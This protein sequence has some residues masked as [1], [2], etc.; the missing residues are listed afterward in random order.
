MGFLH[1]L[2]GVKDPLSRLRRAVN[3]QRWADVLREE[4]VLQREHLSDEMLV[5]LDETVESAANRL[6]EINLHEGEACLRSGDQEGAVEHFQLAA[7]HARSEVLKSL[8][9]QHLAG[10]SASLDAVLVSK[11]SKSCC[12][13]GCHSTADTSTDSIDEMDMELRLELSLSSYPP[14][15]A[16]RYIAADSLFKQALLL[17][18]DGD[19]TEAL[20][21]FDAVDKAEQD[22]LYYFERGSLLVRSGETAQGRRCLQRSVEL[23]PR[24]HLA[25]ETL[26]SL[27][28]MEEQPA[29]AEARLNEMLS[30]EISTTFCFSRLAQIYA[31]KNDV[32]AAIAYGEQALASGPVEIDIIVLQSS[33]LEKAGQIAEAEA[34][35]LTLPSG[36]CGGGAHYL[37][38]EFWLRHGKSLN[39][40]LEAFKSESRQDPTNLRWPLRIAQTYF[41]LKWN[42]DGQALVQKILETPGLQAD[43][44][45]EAEQI[46]SF[47]GK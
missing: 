6:A 7:G 29:K 30:A 33:F 9:V 47:Y 18:F 17:S 28:L 4:E 12:S 32:E 40:A 36:G 15:L 35:L 3:Q 25:L 43:L 42:K 10:A 39:Q 13:S 34:I 21:A 14:D 44:R 41:A 2:F 19:E 1:K 11:D 23:N 5:E 27:D 46:L 31:G 24:Q 20:K 16:A 37:L 45:Q 38:A 22:D 26:V 8:L